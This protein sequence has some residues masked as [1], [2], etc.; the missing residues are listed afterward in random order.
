MFQVSIRNPRTNET[1]FY[2]GIEVEV[3]PGSWGAKTEVWIKPEP[4]NK[5]FPHRNDEFHSYE[6]NDPVY[7]KTGRI[8]NGTFFEMDDLPDEY[9]DELIAEAM[10]SQLEEKNENIPMVEY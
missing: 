3:R 7:I 1:K 5:F 9:R 6:T 8:Y 10:F 2:Y 4:K